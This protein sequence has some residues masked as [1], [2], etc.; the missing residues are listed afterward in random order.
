MKD[1]NGIEIKTGDIVQITGAYFKNDNGLYFVE[2]SPGDPSWSG[3]DYSLR[4]ISKSGKISAA[5]RN[6]C[7]W[8]IGIFVSDHFK[9]AEARCWNEAHATIEVKKIKNM[10]EVSAYFQKKAED[11]TERIKRDTWDFGEDSVIVKTNRAIQAHYLSVS[12]AIQ[13][14]GD[15]E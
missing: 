6:I 9:A 13:G 7:F 4:R 2:A 15:G 5:K 8:P 3:S 11:M 1:K 10:A 12:A 14:G